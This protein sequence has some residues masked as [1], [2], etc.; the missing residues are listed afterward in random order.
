MSNEKGTGSRNYTYRVIMSQSKD[1]LN[2]IFQDIPGIKSCLSGGVSHG[3]LIFQEDQPHL[4]RVSSNEARD[5]SHRNWG[6]LLS[7]VIGLHKAAKID[8]ELMGE[9][10]I[11]RRKKL[12]ISRLIGLNTFKS[13]KYSSLLCFGVFF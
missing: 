10:F 11:L 2:P 8:F 13:H 3:F 12:I 1:S 4:F 5:I 7:D 9:S 6:R